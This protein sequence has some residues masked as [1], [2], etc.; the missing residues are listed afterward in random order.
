MSKVT[1]DYVK[2]AVIDD[3]IYKCRLRRFTAERIYEALVHEEIT[4]VRVEEQDNEND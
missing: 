2:S 4:H 1:I 3:L